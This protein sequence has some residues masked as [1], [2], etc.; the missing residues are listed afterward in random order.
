MKDLPL[1]PDVHYGKITKQPDPNDL[2]L[3]EIDDPEDDD[4]MPKTIDPALI[5]LLGF[6]PRELEEDEYEEVPHQDGSI[7]RR[8]KP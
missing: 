7:L 4:E 6:D 5:K 3:P 1:L 2:E 8:K